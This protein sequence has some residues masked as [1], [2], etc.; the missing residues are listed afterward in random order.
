MKQVLKLE[1]AAQLA[2]ALVGLYFL[3]FHFSWYVWVG[4]FFLPDISMIGYL[5]GSRVGAILYN[6]VHHK[7]IGILIL[8]VGLYTNEHTLSLIGMLLF[9]HSAFDRMMGYGLKL[10]T[11]FHHTHLGMI[12]KQKTNKDAIEN[13]SINPTGV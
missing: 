11:S 12:G 2:A 5:W 3:P 4:L 9:A 1:E 8:L 10:T 6:I 7:A 13:M